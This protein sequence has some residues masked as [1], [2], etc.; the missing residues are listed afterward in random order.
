MGSRSAYDVIIVGA[1]SVGTPTALY[2]AEA[3]VATLVID[4]YDNNPDAGPAWK[5]SFG[6]HPKSF[7]DRPEFAGGEPLQKPS[8]PQ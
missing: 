6:H 1:G 2:L 5:Q 8:R 7:P 4:H 3:G